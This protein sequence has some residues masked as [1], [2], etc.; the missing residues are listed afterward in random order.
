[1]GIIEPFARIDD[2]QSYLTLDEFLVE[3]LD[4]QSDVWPMKN[5]PDK[6]YETL[7]GQLAP[8]E[9]EIVH[10][11]SVEHVPPMKTYAILDASKF[12]SGLSEFEDCGLPFR[13]LFKGDAAEEQKDVAP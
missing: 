11:G 3:P 6:L 7:F 10:Y 5:V 9:A 8:T 13:C 12:Q 4:R 2:Q 1:M